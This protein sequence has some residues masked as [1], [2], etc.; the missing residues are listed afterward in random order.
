MEKYEKAIKLLDELCGKGK[1]NVIA[2]STMSL[3]PSEKPR[4]QVRMVDAYYEDGRFYVSSSLSSRKTLEIS[5]NNEV[6]IAGLD[7]FTA[8]GI[9]ENLGWVKDEKNADIR[10]KMKQYFD[11]F[12]HHGD[13][14][15]PD[16]IVL[17]ITLTNARIIDHEQRY[18]EQRYEV[19][20][21]NNTAK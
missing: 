2:L 16:S 15:N 10:R 1:D 8:D 14:D 13:E 20:F 4:P 12:D 9:A 3:L 17:R 19:D 5:K 21:M 6:A 18:N 7:W 11:W